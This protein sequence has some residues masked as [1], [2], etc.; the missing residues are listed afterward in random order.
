MLIENLRV[1]DN[2]LDTPEGQVIGPTTYFMEV[3]VNTEEVVSV[4]INSETYTT[5]HDLTTAHLPGSTP[6]VTT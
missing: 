2:V 4:P 6:E 1:V 5:L 3:A